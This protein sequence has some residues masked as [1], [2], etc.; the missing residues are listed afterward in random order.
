MTDV[1]ATISINQVTATTGPAAVGATITG[2]QGPQGEPGPA[3]ATDYND[4]T[5]KPALSFSHPFTN[6]ASVVVTHNLNRYPSVTVVDTAGD[7]VIG[8]VK[9]DSLNQLTVTFSSATGGTVFCN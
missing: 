6:S 8:N 5:N 9:Y 4:L 7:E 1:A 2:S 3:G